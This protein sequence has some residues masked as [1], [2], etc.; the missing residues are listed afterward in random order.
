MFVPSAPTPRDSDQLFWWRGL[1]SGWVLTTNL[2]RS[3][4]L[5]ENVS[6]LS[7]FPK[8][9]GIMGCFQALEVLKIASGQGCILSAAPCTYTT[10]VPALHL[11][12]IF[13][14]F[15]WI[16]GERIATLGWR[17]MLCACVIIMKTRVNSWSVVSD[18]IPDLL[19][20]WEQLSNLQIHIILTLRL[21]FNICFNLYNIIMSSKQYSQV[22][23]AC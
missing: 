18:H 3:L 11:N 4:Y 22:G 8:V 21:A 1:R 2:F 12:R 13:C 10:F 6:E 20:I 15:I 7:T 17:G 16:K 14:L 9:P 19:F 23:V 5:Y